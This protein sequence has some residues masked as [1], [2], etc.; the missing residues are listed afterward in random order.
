MQV[1]CS[2]LS[3]KH[4]ISAAALHAGVSSLHKGQKLLRVKDSRSRIVTA[5]LQLLF[6]QAELF[7]IQRG[8][9]S[10]AIPPWQRWLIHLMQT[11]HSSHTNQLLFWFMYRSHACLGNPKSVEKHFQVGETRDIRESVQSQMEQ[12]KQKPRSSGPNLGWGC[13]TAEF[14][15]AKGNK[16]GSVYLWNWDS[17][18]LSHRRTSKN[19]PTAS[20][21][22]DSQ[23]K[24][25]AG[26]G[27]QHWNWTLG[28]MQPQ[29]A[30]S[31]VWLNLKSK[32]W[33]LV[34]ELL[35]LKIAKLRHSLLFIFCIACSPGKKFDNAKHF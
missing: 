12:Q 5:T 17:S 4:R 11:W 24:K 19:Y 35:L 15:T 8:E 29:R 32:T 22:W 9:T 20:F 13:L 30:S 1:Q 10:R 7:S 25:Y 28:K 14:S 27:S 23:S 18:V 31:N 34:S 21:H 33:L 3:V 26:L 16:P 2:S 6:T